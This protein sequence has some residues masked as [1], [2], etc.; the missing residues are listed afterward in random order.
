MAL[1]VENGDPSLFLIKVLP[2]FD[3][4]KT[5]DYEQ[6]RTLCVRLFSEYEVEQDEWR[7]REVFELFDADANGVLDNQEIHSCCNWIHAIVNPVNVLLVVDVQNDFIDGTLA[8]RKCGFGQDGLEVVQPINRLLK[9]GRWDKVIYTQDWHPENHISFFENLAMRELH[10]K[11]EITKETAK[12]FDTVVF[13]QP[14]ITQILWPKH[15]VKNTWGAELHKDLLI[16]PSSE[17]VHKGQDPDKESYSAFEDAEGSL[18]LKRILS[19]VGATHLYA[20]G[21]AYDICVKQTCLDCLRLGYPVAVIEDCCRSVKP[22][23]ETTTTYIENG[24]L[25]ERSD[26]ILSLVND[27]KHSLVMAHQAAKFINQTKLHIM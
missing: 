12:P 6:F 8:L 1:P 27:G 10:P 5:F 23:S 22:D 20:C 25:V 19:A 14:H 3:V 16:I 2:G 15:C 17:R 7:V 9:E 4:K 24:A 11:S 13:L 26:R 18:K 21:I